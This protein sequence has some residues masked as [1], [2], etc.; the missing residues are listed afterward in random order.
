MEQGF[1]NVIHTSQSVQKQST[2]R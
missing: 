1:I 2:R